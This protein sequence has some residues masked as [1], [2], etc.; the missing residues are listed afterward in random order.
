MT[1]TVNVLILFSSS[2]IGGAERS[3]T[4]MAR[5]SSG[6]VRYVL[7]TLDG[8]GPWADWASSL[9]MEVHVLGMSPST[10]RRRIELGAAKRLTGLVRRLGCD[11]IYVVGL[12]A[13]VLV[14]LLRPLLGSVRLVNAVRWNPDS[15]S[16]LDR[17]FR[18]VEKSFGRWSDLY[19]CNSKIAASTL[20]D[21]I[22]VPAEKVKVIYNGLSSMPPEDIVFAPRM[23]QVVTVANLSPRKGHAEYV[24]NVILPLRKS[25]VDARFLFVGRDEMGGI[26]QRM[27][28]RL[29]VED[30]IEFTG[31]VDD[32]S[33]ILARSMIF[34]LPSLW[35]EGCPTAVLEAMAHG[36]P[37]VAFSVDGIPEMITD[38][39]EGMLVPK[40]DYAAMAKAICTL[41]SDPVLARNLG[42]SGRLRV[43]R[44]FQIDRCVRQHA[45]VFGRL[46]SE[47]VGDGQGL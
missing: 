21:R 47:G 15:D 18:L 36:L 13:S 32:V 27:V 14:R 45:D 16:R 8:P 35:N 19:I 44:E 7:A 34:V 30:V 41:L 37:I 11:L 1:G 17:L 33:S 5:A 6:N 25:S 12:R 28:K 29:G 2:E 9:G 42:R 23:R 26:V 46:V 43:G 40:G 20:T 38:G 39:R 10:R 4:R 24:E 3:L 22:G 31:F